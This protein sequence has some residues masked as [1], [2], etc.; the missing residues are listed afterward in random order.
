[1]WTRRRNL[2]EFP[3]LRCRHWSCQRSRQACTR[4]FSRLR[5]RS[6]AGERTSSAVSRL[7]LAATPSGY[8]RDR[9]GLGSSAH[10]HRFQHAALVVA[11]SADSGGT[12]AGTTEALQHGKVKVFVNTVGVLAPGNSKLVRIG[13]IPFPQEPWESF[14]PLFIAPEEKNGQLFSRIAP[15]SSPSVERHMESIGVSALV[16]ESLSTAAQGT[17]PEAV[18]A[19]SGKSM[20]AESADD[21]YAL[22]IDTVLSLLKQPQSEEWLADKLCARAAQMKDWLDRGARQGGAF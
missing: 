19:E 1:M 18:T 22:V 12:W 10:V 6:E 2:C 4:W 16:P 20:E 9:G 8:S 3:I 21:A 17:T 7:R 15:A 11:S 14:R 5:V 13:G